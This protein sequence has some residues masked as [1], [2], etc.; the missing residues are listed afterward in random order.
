MPVGWP[1]YHSRVP[2]SRSP[3]Q[4]L[5]LLAGATGGLGSQP[6]RTTCSSGRLWANPSDY[7][8]SQSWFPCWSRGKTRSSV[9]QGFAHCPCAREHLGLLLGCRFCT[10]RSLVRMISQSV[11][12]ARTKYY[13]LRGFKNRHL[14]CTVLRLGAQ[15]QGTSMVRF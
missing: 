1:S 4:L 8:L 10:S 12:A 5:V 6:P 15:D 3:S 11:W 14:I 7:S 2:L 9:K 13:R